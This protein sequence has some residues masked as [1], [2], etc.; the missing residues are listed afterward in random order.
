MGESK[1]MGLSHMTIA[2]G[3]K[4]QRLVCGLLPLTFPLF[5]AIH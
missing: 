4:T 1:S 3:P 5:N 2:K